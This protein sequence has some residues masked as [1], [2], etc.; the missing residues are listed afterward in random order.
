MSE[1]DKKWEDE[2]SQEGTGFLQEMRG[3]PIHWS[4][5]RILENNHAK[6][7]RKKSFC[8]DF[9]GFGMDPHCSVEIWIQ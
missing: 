4:L 9:A 7:R 1:K 3:V 6:N 2:Q 5:R 8:L